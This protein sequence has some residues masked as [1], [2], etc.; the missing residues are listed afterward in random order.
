MQ[1][2]CRYQISAEKP[3]PGNSDVR[4]VSKTVSQTRLGQILH[5][6]YTTKDIQTQKRLCVCSASLILPGDLFFMCCPT[7][8]ESLH[9]GAPISRLHSSP[10][11]PPHTHTH[12]LTHTHAHSASTFFDRFLAVLSDHQT[13]GADLPGRCSHCTSVCV[14]VCCAECV[15]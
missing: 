4:D 8:S 1:I 11:P 6:F 15:I 7:L 9:M 10:T 13:S 3:A 5:P 2:S 14:C 12:T